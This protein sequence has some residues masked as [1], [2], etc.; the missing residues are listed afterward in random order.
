MPRTEASPGDG[1]SWR[2][3]G[4]PEEGFRYLRADGKPLRS[5]AALSR[6]DSLVIPPAWTDV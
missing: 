4:S 1:A 2:R 5:R 3:V 6:I